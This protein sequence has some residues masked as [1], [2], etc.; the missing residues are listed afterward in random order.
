MEVRGKIPLET[1]RFPMISAG[2]LA[3]AGGEMAAAEARSH[4][5]R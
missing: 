5:R 2:C 4:L 1:A 3:A